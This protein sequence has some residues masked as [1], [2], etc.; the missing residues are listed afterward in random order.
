MMLTKSASMVGMELGGVIL[1]SEHHLWTD[2]HHHWNDL[3]SPL[4]M[5]GE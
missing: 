3:M 1:D 2:N 5:E 4:K